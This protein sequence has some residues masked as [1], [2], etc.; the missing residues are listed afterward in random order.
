MHMYYTG[1]D[2][3]S[4]TEIDA[5]FPEEEAVPRDL[6][7]HDW[8]E[9]A[10]Q[11]ALSVHDFSDWLV[12]GRHELEI[13]QALLGTWT[14]SLRGA[15]CSSLGDFFERI[16]EDSREHSS[17]R[18]LDLGAGRL[19]ACALASFVWRTCELDKCRLP[20]ET[21]EERVEALAARIV[22]EVTTVAAYVST[23]RSTGAMRKE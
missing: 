19:H 3:L 16:V 21:E 22:E 12:H 14:T 6:R 17:H 5:I 4:D 18:D 13:A 1:F 15:D 2:W 11:R 23:W 9:G 20:Q 7:F 8:D 10:E